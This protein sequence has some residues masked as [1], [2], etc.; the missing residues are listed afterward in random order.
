[1]HLVENRAR[2]DALPLEA[3]PSM[4]L[5]APET[6]ELI[7][8][9][10][11]QFGEVTGWRLQF[12]PLD[13]S[14]REIRADL[15][16]RA[17]C[18][19]FTE[20]SAGSRPAGFLSME[21]ATGDQT[22]DRLVEATLLAESL[23][24]VLGRLAHTTAQLNQRNQDVAT[25]LHLGMAVPGQDDLAFSLA[26]YLKAA[27][28]LTGSWSAAFF[29]LDGATER[30]RLRAVYNLSREDMP[31]PFRELRTGH[32]DL[33]ALADDPVVLGAHSP[34][35]HPLLPAEMRAGV[36]AAVQ[37]ET[38]PFGTLW[39][40][41]R[42]AKTYTQRDLQVLQSIAAQVAAVL[43]RTA[44]LRGSEQHDR[45]HRDLIA[46]SETQPDSVL[47]DLPNDP[48]FELAA[49]CTS[50]YELGGDLCEVLPLSDD[51]TALA[52]GDASGNSIPAAMIMS[53]VRGALRTHPADANETV[54]LLTRLNRAL[55]SI[56]G[57][58][59][60]M[61]LCYGVYD[62]ARKTFTYTNAGHPA[63]LFV[64][65]GKARPLESH[66]LLLGVVGEVNY[67]QSTLELSE[68]DL[69]VIYSD[70]ISEARSRDHELF[71]AEGISRAV[72]NYCGE[73]AEKVLEAIWDRVDEYASG[74]EGSDDRTLMVLKVR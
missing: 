35:G 68:G 30:L 69:L 49:R 20:V 4:T 45:I 34:G 74:G 71:R 25:L 24:Q 61:S 48:R 52:V 55:C 60:F 8:E 19:W 6:H 50:C 23:S 53:A 11:R 26:Q 5:T 7:P 40:Y 39:V 1:V 46:A 13:R 22:A 63:P 44:L 70:G 18:C 64:R 43:E 58:H 73:P 42:R 9:L 51:R 14:P 10:C 72:A 36:C 54:G 2:P 3:A 37:S 47:K 66:G 16:N 67:Q 32:T 27:A 29:L 28:H 31:Y 15:E 56:T 12:T 38:V 33:R 65:H 59:Q 62:A 41:D 17:A 57:A 21:S